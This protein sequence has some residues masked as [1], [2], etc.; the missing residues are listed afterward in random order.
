VPTLSRG[1]W[2]L[3]RKPWGQAVLWIIW[4]WLTAHFFSHI[5]EV[6]AKDH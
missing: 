6:S 2:T 3:Y 5:E 1:I 4:G